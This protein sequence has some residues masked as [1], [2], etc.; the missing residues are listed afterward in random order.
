MQGYNFS[1]LYTLPGGLYSSQRPQL[2]RTWQWVL[3][4]LIRRPCVP[5]QCPPHLRLRIF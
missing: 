4:L 2:F 5:F 1:V 3:L